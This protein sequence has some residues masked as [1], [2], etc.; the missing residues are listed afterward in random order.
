MD[1]RTDQLTAARINVIVKDMPRKSM[2]YSARAL[3]D[4]GATLD[5]AIRVL[6]RLLKRR[7]GLSST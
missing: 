6:T 1:R 5:P 2:S 4:V 3:Y 7:V